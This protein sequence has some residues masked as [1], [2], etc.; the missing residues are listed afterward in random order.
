M[1]AKAILY[2]YFILGCFLANFS[3]FIFTLNN[4]VIQTLKLDFSE[5]MLVR[6]LLQLILFSSIICY[7][8]YSILPRIGSK[9]LLI[10]FCTAFQGI[11]GG[12]MIICGVSCV[13]FMPL[14]DAMTLLFTAPFSTI[15]LAAIFLKHRLRLF[16]M[17]ACLLL[18]AGAVLVIRP[19]FI[20]GAPDP[21]D[22]YITQNFNDSFVVLFR[23]VHKDRNTINYHNKWYYI[24]AIIALS[25]AMCD[26]FL[27]I[28]IN[29]CQQVESFVLMW[30]AAIGGLIFSLIGFT[31]D[32]NARMLSPFIVNISYQ[33]WLG[34]V[35]IAFSGI[36]GYF[37]MTKSLQ[38]VDPTV[39][40]FIRA[41]EIV[42]GYFFQAFFMMQI[43]TVLSIT[44]ACLVLISVLCITLQ[45]VIIN[46]IPEKIRYIF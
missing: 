5:V 8:G 24:G 41:L 22:D 9:P 20:F 11:W 39:V 37:C 3:G 18:G 43:P 38:M 1:I 33:E 21:E 36:I 35:G 25:S 12:L 15:V 45:D 13:T 23:E 26:G 42:F 16:R 34:Y 6:S 44:G 29:Y 4:C 28:T 14:G 7:R 17:T 2:R 19:Q 40:S 46:A 30:W 27:N 10:Q 31:F 32:T